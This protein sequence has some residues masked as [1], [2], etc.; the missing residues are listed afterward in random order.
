MLFVPPFR[1]HNANQRFRTV[2]FFEGSSYV[3]LLVTMVLK[4]RFGMAGPNLVVGMLHGFLFLTYILFLLE[5]WW[6]KKWSFFEVVMAFLLSL[7]PIG[8]FIGEAVWW[9]KKD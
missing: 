3:L 4:Y 2:A 1:F 9:H 6:R 8:T 5:A 7:L